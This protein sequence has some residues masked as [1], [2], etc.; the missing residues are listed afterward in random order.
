VVGFLFDRLGS[1]Q[2]AFLTTAIVAGMGFILI[3]ML[4]PIAT[5]RDNL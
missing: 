5:K 3:W 4:R 1:Y 2:I